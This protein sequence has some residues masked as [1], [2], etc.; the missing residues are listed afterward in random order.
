MDKA[1]NQYLIRVRDDNWNTP[2][3]EEAKVIALEAK[4]EKTQKQLANLKRRAGSSGSSGGDD[5]SHT[6]K[7]GGGKRKSKKP[8][9]MLKPPTDGKTTKFVEGKQYWWCKE[10]KA[11]GT[12]TFEDCNA[13]KARLA[14]ESSQN[15]DV[16]SD[17]E[18]S[19]KLKLTKA[20]AT[21]AEAEQEE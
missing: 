17:N 21:I 8:D 18:V 14:R 1:H 19:R 9:W 16:K 3:E 12:H 13:R 2:T 4:L 5:S 7:K 11:W 6:S 15:K 20:L 10:H